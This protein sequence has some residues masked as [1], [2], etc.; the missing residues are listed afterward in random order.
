MT[1]RLVTT[2]LAVA[3][4]SAAALTVPAIASPAAAQSLSITIGSPPPSGYVWAPGYRQAP[5]HHYHAVP[6]RWDRDGDGI[7]NRYDRYDN[8][9]GAFGDWDR[10]GVP[11]MFDRYNNRHW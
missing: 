7:P 9:R 10:D 11:N 8:R 6:S 1:K 2:I 3:A 4:V 5:P